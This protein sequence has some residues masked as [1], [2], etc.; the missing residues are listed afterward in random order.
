MARSRY[1]NTVVERSGTPS[2]VISMAEWSRTRRQ[3]C[4][5]EIH[6]Q[7]LRDEVYGLA[8]ASSQQILE[9]VH[10]AAARARRA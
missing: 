6:E 1:V 4:Q 7:F 8:G 5:V 3:P 2:N 10:V 9:S